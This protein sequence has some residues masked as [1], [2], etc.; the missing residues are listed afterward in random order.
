MILLNQTLAIT[1]GVD[2]LGKQENGSI[3]LVFETYVGSVMADGGFLSIFVT[4]WFFL[5][6]VADR[7]DIINERLR[8][9][10]C[11]KM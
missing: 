10:V 7:I 6:N 3:Y 8:F 5:E 11:E 9:D 1:L 2:L 4:Y